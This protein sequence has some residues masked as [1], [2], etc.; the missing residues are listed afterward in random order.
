MFGW[1]QKDKDNALRKTL[2][3]SDY[4]G[5]DVDDLRHAIEKGAN[6]NVEDDH[7]VPIICTAAALSSDYH[8]SQAVEALID[9]GANLDVRSPKSGRTP[10]HLAAMRGNDGTVRLLLQRHANVHA[11]GMRNESILET[12]LDH[13]EDVEIINTLIGAGALEGI[14]GRE[15]IDLLCKAIVRKD[16]SLDVIEL[17]AR[18]IP[19]FNQPGED[20]GTPLHALV[21]RGKFSREI[22]DFVLSRPGIDLERAYDGETALGAALENKKYE[23]AEALIRAGAGVFKAHNDAGPL[24]ML[25]NQDAVR[26]IPV[27]LEAYAR[28]GEK[29]GQDMQRALEAAAGHGHIKSVKVLLAAGADANGKSSDGV[30]PMMRAA[31]GG[32]VDVMT[33]LAAAGASVDAVD[34]D[35]ANVGTY[36]RNNKKSQAFIRKLTAPPPPFVPVVSG[37]FTR[38]ND[39][40]LEVRQGG[41]LT[42]TFNFS[43]QQAIYRDGQ[44]MVVRNFNEIQRQEAVEEA[45]EKLVALGGKPPGGGFEKPLPALKGR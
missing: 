8:A 11:R 41:S 39:H 24:E 30:T 35:G 5:L 4:Y 36:A 18:D 1:S 15:R 13:S 32:H 40:S 2:R 25:A 6:V 26:M 20:Y 28:A 12:A 45:R 14:E 10:L 33:A 37:D 3:H 9:A 38:L 23:T 7:G 22:C 16:C 17:L 21:S 34:N 43:L 42:V 19:D 29:P 44:A 27:I 31:Y